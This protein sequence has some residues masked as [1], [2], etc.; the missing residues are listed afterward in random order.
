MRKCTAGQ[1]YIVSPRDTSV[2]CKTHLYAF[3]VGS[4]AAVGIA[5]V[6]VAAD[7]AGVGDADTAAV[8]AA[9]SGANTSQTL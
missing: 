3:L 9:V 6:G 5:A 1:R 7:A 8:V 4:V 2:P